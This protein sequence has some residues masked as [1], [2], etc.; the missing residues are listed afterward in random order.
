MEQMIAILFAAL[1][2]WA[3]WR[4]HIQAIAEIKFRNKIFALRDELRRNA[5]LGKIEIHSPEFIFFDKTFC[6]VLKN[7]YY[8]TFFN[9]FLQ[10]KKQT[11]HQEF[12]LFLN[13][14]QERCSKMPVLNQIRNEYEITVSR[15]LAQQHIPI[16]SMIFLA[17]K[18]SNFF[19]GQQF[20]PRS[21]YYSPRHNSFGGYDLAV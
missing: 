18:L 16:L 12:E 5:Y 1:F 4:H 20:T 21:V 17:K 19:F 14:L 15:Y 8:I 3:L 10:F 13:T 11:N 2:L 6:Q 7:S 9:A